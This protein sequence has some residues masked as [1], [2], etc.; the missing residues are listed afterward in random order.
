ME[1]VQ[2]PAARRTVPPRKRSQSGA[3]GAPVGFFPSVRVCGGLV[4]LGGRRLEACFV[5]LWVCAL[6]ASWRLRAGQSGGRSPL[7]L[8]VG[9][10]WALR[11]WLS[12]AGC[13]PHSALVSSV[14][15][16]RREREREESV[17]VDVLRLASRAWAPARV[18]RLSARRVRQCLFCRDGTFA[19]VTFGCLFGSS[20]SCCRTSGQS[21]RR[22]V[23]TW[24]LSVLR[25]CACSLHAWLCGLACG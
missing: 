10:W 5:S 14:R 4:R 23:P 21:P 3:R 19:P 15:C 25:A 24:Q 18:R 9:R 16:A 12:L 13:H 22:R 7:G 20:C 11:T 17:R 1:S 8:C 6:G 2:A